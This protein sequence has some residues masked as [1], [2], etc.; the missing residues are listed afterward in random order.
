MPGLQALA[1]SVRLLHEVGL[2][3]VSARILDR[4]D[5]VRERAQRSGWTVIGSTRPSDRSGI[6]PLIKPGVDP[7]SFVSAARERGVALACRRGCVR[8]S[9]HIYNDESDLDRLSEVL[10]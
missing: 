1:P 9:A 10:S 7:D 8:V 3:A 4:A 5:Q 6:V 2:D